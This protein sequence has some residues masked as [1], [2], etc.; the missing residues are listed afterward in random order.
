VVG[1]KYSEPRPDGKVSK[2]N[3]SWFWVKP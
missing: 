3:R 2:R 1:G